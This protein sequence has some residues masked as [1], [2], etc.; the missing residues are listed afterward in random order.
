MTDRKSEIA[1]LRKQLADANR[2]ADAAEAENRTLKEVLSCEKMKRRSAG[3]RSAKGAYFMYV[4]HAMH[5]LPLEFRHDHQGRDNVSEIARR[6]R[7]L[8]NYPKF[9]EKTDAS[10]VQ[11][12]VRDAITFAVEKLT[13]PTDRNR[14]DLAL[15]IMFGTTNNGRVWLSERQQPMTLATYDGSGRSERPTT[16][17]E[18]FELLYSQAKKRPH[19]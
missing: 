11:R 15:D 12:I 3:R 8:P 10:S 17:A 4:M 16:V 18:L 9:R 2:R 19:R 13:R 6:L 14:R 5:E 1:A 7:C